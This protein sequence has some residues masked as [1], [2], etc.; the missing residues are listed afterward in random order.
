[1]A[2]N[3]TNPP[4][5]GNSRSPFGAQKGFHA[6]ARKG[7]NARSASPFLNSL[8]PYRFGAQSAPK[9]SGHKLHLKPEFTFALSPLFA[10]SREPFFL[11]TS[12]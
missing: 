1:M 6:N 2:R 3:L 5:K 4:P 10:L 9:N 7:A 8:C 12:T 11:A